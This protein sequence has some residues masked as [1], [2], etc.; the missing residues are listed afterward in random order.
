VFACAA[1]F[2]LLWL[3]LVIVGSRRIGRVAAGEAQPA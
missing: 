3:P 1:A 2:T